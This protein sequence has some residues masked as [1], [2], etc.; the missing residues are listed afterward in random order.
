MRIFLKWNFLKAAK[1]LELPL[2]V[3]LANR[4]KVSEELDYVRLDRKVK[5]PNLFNAGEVLGGE[6][7][8]SFL[9]AICDS[10]AEQLSGI[11]VRSIS[12]D[13]AADRCGKIHVNDQIIEV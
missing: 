7:K 2:L 9:S 10:I 4:V 6:K 13:G 12:E 5:M 1:V 8:Y 3:M 11:F